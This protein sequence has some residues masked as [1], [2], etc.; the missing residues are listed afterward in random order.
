MQSPSTLYSVQTT[1]SSRLK[2]I[3]KVAHIVVDWLVTKESCMVYGTST[4]TKCFGQYYV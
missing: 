4:L 2:N 1:D 3:G